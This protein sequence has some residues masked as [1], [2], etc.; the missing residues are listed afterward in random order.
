MAV[1]S[2]SI[3]P[4][5]DPKSRVEGF[6]KLKIGGKEASDPWPHLEVEKPKGQGH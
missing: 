1:V 4:V 2:L 3:C 6:R 5:P